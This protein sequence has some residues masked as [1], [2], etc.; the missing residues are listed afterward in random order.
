MAAQIQQF[1]SACAAGRIEQIRQFLDTGLAVDS[2]REEI[3]PLHRA[4]GKDQKAAVELLL[5]HGANKEAL[6]RSGR[7]PL[8]AA[9]TFGFLGLAD[10]LMKAGSS[11]LS[12]V[13]NSLLTALH[14]AV[15]HPMSA[16]IAKQL[17]TMGHPVDA[18]DKNGETPLMAC[19]RDSENSSVLDCLLV[20]GASLNAFSKKRET[21]LHLACYYARDNNAKFLILRGADVLALNKSDKTAFEVYDSLGQSADKVR[22]LNALKAAHYDLLLRDFI[23]LK[24]PAQVV[25][26]QFLSE[27]LADVVITSADGE[28]I[29]AH[30]FVL[31][32]YSRQF[33]AMLTGA[34]AENES[35]KD[36]KPSEV[37]MAQS[38]GAIRALLAYMYKGQCP[39]KAIGAHLHE[40]LEL[41]DQHDLNDVKNECEE[42]CNKKLSTSTVIPHFVTSSLFK[43]SKLK[44]ACVAM[45][46][47]PTNTLTIA[48]STPF[49]NLKSTQPE[50]WAELRSLVGAA[51][52]DG[53]GSE[54]A[55]KVIRI[56]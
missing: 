16:A 4:I 32:A 42:Y 11:I 54:P 25:K 48:M 24:R 41:A 19:A 30:K 56:A 6:D 17:I 50:L 7:T 12:V 20:A 51:P 55:L 38:A 31:T 44:A 1:H 39:A 5:Q 45:I 14:V 53:D 2:L 15:A 21:A 28:R 52:I 33:K 10:V 22:G 27:D 36:G 34:W 43:L 9:L 40:L 13:P 46:K 49:M 37:Q 47:N 18:R 29:H 26:K 23:V 35:A 8:L 3:T